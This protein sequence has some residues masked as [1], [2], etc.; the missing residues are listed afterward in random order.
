MIQGVSAPAFACPGV[1]GRK[2]TSDEGNQRQAV[3]TIVTQRVEVPPG[4]ASRYYRPI[5]AK[6]LSMQAAARRP[7]TAAIGTPGPGC[8]LPPAR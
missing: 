3:L 1:V 8:V 5:E 2:H 4:I 6:S 7:E